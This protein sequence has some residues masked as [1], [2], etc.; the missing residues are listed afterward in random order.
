MSASELTKALGASVVKAPDGD[1][2]V[3]PGTDERYAYT[4]YVLPNVEVVQAKYD[5]KFLLDIKTN[6]LTE[7][8]FGLSK[9]TTTRPVLEYHFNKLDAALTEKYGQPTFKADDLRLSR[10]RR[11][12]F[13]TTTIQLQLRY[14]HYADSFELVYGPTKKE[15]KL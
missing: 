10:E 6:L 14:S 8:R 11:W 1:Y 15:S 13:P 4:G 5:V 2:W 7:I 9:P 3:K 12:S